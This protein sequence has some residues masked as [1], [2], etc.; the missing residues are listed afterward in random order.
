MSDR[1][2]PPGIQVGPA[3]DLVAGRLFG[4]HVC[5][6]TDNH[7]HGRERGGP[8]DRRSGAHGLG[9]AEVRHHGGPSRKENVFRLDDAV[10]DVAG[11]GV[12]QGQ[13]HVAED[14]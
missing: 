11:M 12:F 7:P 8:A 9:D 6:G 14:A 10:D 13:G 5:R 4:R 3:V 1:V 2:D